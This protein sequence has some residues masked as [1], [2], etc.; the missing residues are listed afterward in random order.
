MNKAITYNKFLILS[1]YPIYC[2]GPG[3]ALLKSKAVS[4]AGFQHPMAV[5]FG[6]P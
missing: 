6:C 4:C 5:I 2:S 3:L 1:Q